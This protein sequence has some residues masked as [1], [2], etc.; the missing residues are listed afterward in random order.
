MNTKDIILQICCLVDDMLPEIPKHL[1]AKLYPSELTITAV[2]A[3][4]HVG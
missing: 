1:Q 4:P 3:E 2:I